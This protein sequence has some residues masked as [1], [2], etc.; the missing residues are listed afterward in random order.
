MKRKAFTLIE[1]LVVIAIIAILIALLL[2][3]VQRARAQSARAQCLNNLKQI[4]LATQGYHDAFKKFPAGI[5]G[6][7]SLATWQVSVLPYLD[8]GNK[9]QEFDLTTNVTAAVN[10][11]AR[12]QDIPIY[13]C[14]SDRSSGMFPDPVNG[15]PFGRCNYLGNMGTHAW[16]FESNGATVKSTAMTGVFAANTQCGIRHILDGTSTTAFFSE[17]KRGARPSNDG[18]DVT[19][20]AV[21]VWGVGNAATNANNVTAPAACNSPVT[22]YN[23]L[24]L[25][26]CFGPLNSMYTHTIPINSDKNLDCMAQL[27]DQFHIAARS[28]H[29]GGV[30]VAFVDGSVRFVTD[31]VNFGTWQA[32]GTRCGGEVVDDF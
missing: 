11:N 31:G 8:Q 25:Q 10:A 18:T 30:N 29:S 20:V 24:G 6:S 28:Y 14:P 16:Q 17:I 4:A 5:A 32:L 19:Q 9:F 23:Y 13:L 22:T 21:G 12:V 7:P 1:L 27:A 3:A 26:Y 2:A 15:A